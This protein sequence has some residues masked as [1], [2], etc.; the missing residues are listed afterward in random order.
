MK[1]NIA[2]KCKLTIAMTNTYVHIHITCVLIYVKFELP[3]IK[4][5]AC[6]TTAKL[7]NNIYRP[8]LGS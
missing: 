6:S 7:A 2:A 3:T 8:V 4:T 1:K 5:L